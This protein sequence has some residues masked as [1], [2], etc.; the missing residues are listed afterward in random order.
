MSG[1]GLGHM[2]SCRRDPAGLVCGS[3]ALPIL[4]QFSPDSTPDLW[5]STPAVLCH[6]TWQSLSPLTDNLHPQPSRAEKN[7]QSPPPLCPHRS[8]AR[9]T[10][11]PTTLNSPRV[12]ISHA[13]SPRVPPPTT[14]YSPLV[15]T[16]H[17]LSRRDPTLRVP[18]HRV[19][20]PAAL[21]P[22]RVHTPRTAHPSATLSSPQAPPASVPLLSAF[23]PQFGLL[24]RSPLP[25]NTNGLPLRNM[26]ER[27]VYRWIQ[28]RVSRNP[29]TE[30]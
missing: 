2:S 6:S 24:G 12:S 19:P 21:S 11:P 9:R 30:P 22:P 17:V 23:R 16:L 15:F 7:C 18:S 29:S 3:V 28:P 4:H 5:Q 27:W 26:D 1:T 14:L 13:L 10:S 8:A 25:L 20:A